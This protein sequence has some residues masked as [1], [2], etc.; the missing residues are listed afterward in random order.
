EAFDAQKIAEKAWEAFKSGQKEALKVL[1][2]GEKPTLASWLNLGIGTWLF[3][4]LGGFTA[5]KWVGG[6]TIG[7]ALKWVGG[8]LGL[9]TA[10]TAA[11]ATTAKT[12]AT[13]AATASQTVSG[14]SKT[15]SLFRDY[16]AA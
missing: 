14:I 5:L 10:G 13:T 7:P 12:A 16:R 15:A 2:G 11:A 9:G 8:K 1:P 6:K 3:K 4:K